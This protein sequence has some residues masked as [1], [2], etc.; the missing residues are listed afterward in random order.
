L[1]EELNREIRKPHEKIF[2]FV[3][4]AWFAVR[5]ENKEKN[6]VSAPFLAD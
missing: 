5:Y 3:Y 2:D 1:E 4:L 6:R